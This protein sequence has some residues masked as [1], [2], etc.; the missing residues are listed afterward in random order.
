MIFISIY[1][2]LS[3]QDGQEEF[4]SNYLCLLFTRSLQD[5]RDESVN[6]MYIV[7][8][9]ACETVRENHCYVISCDRHEESANHYLCLLLYT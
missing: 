1:F 7:L 8:L 3:L 5:R 2:I 4:V 6:L 9:L